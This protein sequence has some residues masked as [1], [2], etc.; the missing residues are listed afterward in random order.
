MLL[1]RELFV[2]CLAVLYFV[3]DLLCRCADFIRDLLAYCDSQNA[4]TLKLT[5][6]LRGSVVR[7]RVSLTR[8]LIQ[9]GARA[10]CDEDQ[11]QYLGGMVDLQTPLYL[12][13]REGR[14]EVVKLLLEQPGIKI[15][16][17]VDMPPFRVAVING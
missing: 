17:P 2:W 1:I 8:H 15:N 6:M 9:K 14:V 12:A 4:S 7:G 16:Y 5:F 13:V 3:F 11:R 10:D